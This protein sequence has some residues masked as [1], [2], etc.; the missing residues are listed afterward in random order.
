M[1]DFI[2]VDTEGKKLLREIAVINNQGKLIYEAFTQEYPDNYNIKLYLKPLS[3]IIQDFLQIAEDNLII[4]HNVSHDIKVL[5][6]NFMLAGI[7]WRKFKFNCSLRL[8]QVYFPEFPSYSLEYLSKR[9]KLKVNNQYFNP[10][11]AHSARYDAQFTYQLYGKIQQEKYM[12]KFKN[13]VNPFGTTRVDNPFQDHV[14]LPSIYDNEFKILE[15]IIDDIK[16]DKNRQSKGA[17]VIGEPGS[18]KTHLIMRLAKK[19]LQFNRLLFVRC[20]NNSESVLYHI[21]AR[22]LES[23]IH[24]VPNTGFRQIEHLLAHSFVKLISHNQFMTLTQKDKD[25][26]SSVKNNYLGLYEKLGAEGTGKKLAYWEHIEKRTNEWWL[27]QYGIADYS[28]KIIKGIIKFCSYKDPNKK[29]LVAR[30][31]A[32]DELIEEK[33]KLIGLDNWNEEMSREAFSLEAISV[34]S[35]LSL[36]DEPLIIVFDQLE[37]LG[38]EYQTKLLFKFVEAVKEI[39]T[40]VPNSLII[41]NLFPDRWQQFQ[42]LFD[43]SVVDRVSQY[44]VYLEPPSKQEIK[45]ILALKTRDVGIDLKQLF[46][47]S[48]LEDI[49]SHN[50]IRRVLNR[51]ADYYRFKVNK[52]SLLH[53]P[54]LEPDENN[55]NSQQSIQSDSTNLETRLEKLENEFR[56]IKTIFEEIGKVLMPPST[57]SEETI[58][59]TTEDILPIPEL[60]ILDTPSIQNKIQDFL[61]KNKEILD[62]EYKQLQIITDSDDI[63]KLII[64][65]ESFKTVID[66]DIDHMILGKKRVPENCLVKTNSKFYLIGFLQ[67]DG[68]SFTSRI[69]NFNEL[70]INYKNINF[71]LWRD[72]RKPAIEGKIGKEQIVMLNNAPNGQFLVMNQEDRIQFELIYKLITNIQ[73]RDLDVELEEGIEFLFSQMR[74]CWLIKGLI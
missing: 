49:L 54:S 61:S 35:K 52:I 33:L 53:Y 57:I 37:S 58:E 38:L 9:L 27:N 39:F 69:K 26:L 7:P 29:Q 60:Q 31:L 5:R 22:I 3:I 13:T 30:W 36:L 8:A 17:V 66:L 63:G 2:I 32:A 64:I 18:G 6:H 68:S 71:Q 16:Y 45:E 20:P 14:D 11:Q 70:V 25:I 47:E 4:C 1:T 40:H 21:Y 56:Q 67:M 62:Q 65:L 28:P 43:G 46:S 24:Q 34:F 19:R 44:K 15:S 48:E 41:L 10:Q 74:N 55:A 59:E 23:F 51:A 50:S 73:N 42:T 12:N 72:I